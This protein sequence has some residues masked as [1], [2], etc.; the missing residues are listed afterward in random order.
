MSYLTTDT[1]RLERKKLFKGDK[2]ALQRAE[3]HE[4]AIK[5]TIFQIE[6]YYFTDNLSPD[7]IAVELLSINGKFQGTEKQRKELIGYVERVIERK[8]KSDS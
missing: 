2:A 6:R 1:S 8:R 3:L 7:Q 5:R 4:A